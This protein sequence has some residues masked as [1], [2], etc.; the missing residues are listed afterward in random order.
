MLNLAIECSGVAGSVALFDREHFLAQRMLPAEMGSVR[1]LA[2]TIQ[3]MLNDFTP[4]DS[5]R[6]DLISVTCGPGS[7]TG[8][9]VGLATA[10][11][12]CYAWKIPVAPVDTLAAIAYGVSQVERQSE[13]KTTPIVIVPVL[14]AF[15]KQVFA[16]AWLLSDAGETGGRQGRGE[17]T[18]LAEGSR[19]WPELTQLAQSQVLGAAAWQ[20]QPWLGLARTNND[21]LGDGPQQISKEGLGEVLVCGP[22]LRTY[23]PLPLAAVTIAE[24]SLWEPTASSVAQLGWHIY[25]AGGTVSAEK[26]Q[27]NYVR[28]SAAEERTGMQ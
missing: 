12:M 26:L 19:F 8:L 15:R 17:A 9:R 13:R 18:S 16:G 21:L 27:P 5:R 23:A 24:E 2:A 25:Q 3:E 6:V 1:S 4:P 7:F 28:A 20:E 11:M 14:N 22:G 10:Q